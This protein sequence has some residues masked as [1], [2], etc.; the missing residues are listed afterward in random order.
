[1]GNRCIW[2]NRLAKKMLYTSRRSHWL[3]ASCMLL[4]NSIKLICTFSVCITGRS[5]CAVPSACVTLTLLS[6]CRRTL[7]GA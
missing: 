2:D 3:V 1:M 6:M 4:D 5:G 7:Q